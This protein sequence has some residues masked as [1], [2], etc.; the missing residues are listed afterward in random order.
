M[1]HEAWME[2]GRQAYGRAKIPEEWRQVVITITILM[3]A[4]S[5]SLAPVVHPHLAPAHPGPQVVEQLRVDPVP[6]QRVQA[7]HPRGG[8]AWPAANGKGRGS[9]AAWVLGARAKDT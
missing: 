9:S 3:S 5:T 1:K 6:L 2:R 8:G 7:G 4:P